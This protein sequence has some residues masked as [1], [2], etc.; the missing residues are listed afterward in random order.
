MI[1]L[2]DQ[3][4]VR[5]KSPWNNF[6]AALTQKLF[7]GLLL[8]TTNTNPSQVNPELRFIIDSFRA[9]EKPILEGVWI[10]WG[11]YDILLFF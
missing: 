2:K 11:R 8:R 1:Y 6:Y 9:V 7:Q 5:N 3:L 4:V 10:Y